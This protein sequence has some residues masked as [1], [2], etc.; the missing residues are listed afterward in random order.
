MQFF[1]SITNFIDLQ[2]YYEQVCLTKQPGL[3]KVAEKLLNKVIC[4]G[5]QMSN[6]EKRPLRLSQQHYAALD[7]Y[8]LIQLLFKVAKIGAEKEQIGVEDHIRRY[9]NPHVHKDMKNGFS[10]NEETKEDQGGQSA[11]DNKKYKKNKKRTE[12]RRANKHNQ[13]QQQMSQGAGS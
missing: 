6:W 8:C 7:A 11:Y 12:Q 5:E 9:T 1:K 4:K 2:K 3:A 10:R 13:R